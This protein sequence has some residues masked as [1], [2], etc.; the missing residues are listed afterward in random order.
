MAQQDAIGQLKDRFSRQLGDF[1]NRLVVIWH[2]SDGSFEGDFASLEADKVAGARPLHLARAEEGSM[3]SLKKALYRDY[4]ADDFLIYSRTQKDLSPRALEGNWIADV[5][6]IADH[7]QADFASMLMDDLGAAD[8]AAEGVELFKGFFNAQ[9]RKQRFKRLMPSAQSKQDVALGVIGS[10]LGSK[11]LSTECLVRTYIVSLAG[12]GS[13]LEAL[14]RYG[15]D[16]AW[17]SFLSKR[18]GYSGDLES[19]EDLAAH[20]L[21]TALSFQLP[22]GSLDGLENRISFPHG[23]FCLNIVHDWMDD[24]QSSDQLYDLCR[25]I[26]SLCNLEQRFSQSAAAA[27]CD[28]DIF[29]CINERIISDLFT[30]MANGADRTD[31]ASKVL[32]RRRDMRWHTRVS[33]YFDALEAAVSAQRFHRDH[34]QGFHYAKPD[35]VWRCYTDKRDGWW[36]MDSAY[37]SFCK[38]ADAAQK[39]TYDLP[40]VLDDSLEALASWMEHI[41]VNWFLSESNK[42]WVSAAEKSWSEVGY[43]EGVRRQRRFFDEA[44]VSGAAGAKK[45]LVVISDA[46]RYEVAAELSQRLE[47]DTKGSADLESMQSV[48]PS[49]TEFGMAALLPH[50]SLSFGIEDGCVYVNDGMPT[51]SC[52]QREAVLRLRKPAARCIQS[53]DLFSAKRA[54]RKELVGDAEIV[55]VYHNKIDS[56][57]EEYSTEHDVFNECDTAIDDIVALVKIATGDLNFTRVVITADHGFLYTREPL[58]ESG[59]VSGKDIAGS[60]IRLGRRYAISDDWTEDALFIKVNMDDVRGASYVGIAPRE[61]IRIKKPGPGENYVHGGLSLQECCVP[62]IQFRNKRAGAKGYEESRPAA[63]QMLSTSRRVTSLMFR[64][65]LFQKDRVEGKV[66]PA[67][68]EV[69]M[70]DAS[71]N[72]VSDVCKAHADMTN[73]DETARVCRLQLSLKAGRQ[74]DP[75]KTY[76]LLCRDKATGQIAW[77]EEYQIDIPFV[78]MDD[79]GF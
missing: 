31:E 3:F 66:L 12:G 39:S 14:G 48:F 77:K 35:D 34:I 57:G 4:P 5:E 28:A 9:D 29:P 73:P 46:L 65:E 22:E 72:E 78:P 59:K 7:F 43:V 16:A 55:Y 47:Q 18:I 63:F 37:R 41:Y 8:G 2:D 27:L 19:L 79:F 1:E 21:V 54:M 11:D 20:V 60:K 40:P 38:A 49:I 32:Q 10:L 33:P 24:E 53:K 56:V 45:T 44:V 70:T 6:L 25:R 68:Y 58:E 67:E 75:K 74:Y 71:G 15:A 62:V 61:C 64:I 76:F 17:S 30:S 51:A 13:P 50:S 52:G 42:C 69:Y 26:E 36:R 23:Q